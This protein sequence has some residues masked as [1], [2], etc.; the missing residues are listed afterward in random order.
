MWRSA[1]PSAQYS[2]SGWE[3][4]V[5]RFARTLAPHARLPIAVCVDRYSEREEAG[6]A[7]LCPL[8]DVQRLRQQTIRLWQ[9]LFM[10]FASAS[11]TESAFTR[12]ST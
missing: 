2:R 11:R 1:A 7:T 5:L 6:R 4:G 10:P 12:A 3:S 9:A 8:A